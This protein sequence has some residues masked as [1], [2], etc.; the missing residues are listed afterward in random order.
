MRIIDKNTDF[1]DYLQD[2]TDTL[3]F[4]RRGS[5]LLTK[6][7]ICDNLINRHQRDK[8]RYYFLIL[9]CGATF[10]LFL[11]YVTE[12]NHFN[13]PVDYTLELL[14][15]WKNFNKPNELL[16]IDLIDGYCYCTYKMRD[17]KTHEY[18]LDLVRKYTKDM[19]DYID[20]Y[21]SD[22]YDMRYDM[23]NITCVRDTKVMIHNGVNKRIRSYPILRSCGMGKY[24]D[25]QDIFCAIEEYFSIEKQKL[26]TTEPK[27]ATNDD[28][29][30]MHGFDT[31][32]S[33]RNC[34]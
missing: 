12:F 13:F 11:A 1:Y 27:G 32:I 16:K 17:K 22:S 18:Q 24:I 21:V 31:K 8:E 10:W 9:Q 7:D 2:P 19:V 14:Y 33:F 30:I 23:R 29:I 4:D 5:F 6:K 15:T 25:S 34:K 20:H 26:E 28:K 3:V